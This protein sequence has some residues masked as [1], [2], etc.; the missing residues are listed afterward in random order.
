MNRHSKGMRVSVNSSQAP[1]RPHRHPSHRFCVNPQ[2]PEHTQKRMHFPLPFTFTQTEAQHTHTSCTCLVHRNLS[3]SDCSVSVDG[4]QSPSYFSGCTVVHGGW[5]TRLHS[6]LCGWTFRL[7]PTVTA[8][9]VT[10]C[11]C[12]SVGKFLSAT[13]G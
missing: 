7:L 9:T 12:S 11:H 6:G 2:R 5:T 8:C 4:K 13:A 3:G 1:P 10:L